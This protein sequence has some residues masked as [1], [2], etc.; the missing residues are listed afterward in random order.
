MVRNPNYHD[1]IVNDESLAL[2]ITQQEAL[3][4]ELLNKFA[5]NPTLLEGL[6]LAA[7][8]FRSPKI[9]IAL[10][11]Y[12]DRRERGKRIPFGKLCCISKQALLSKRGIKA[13]IG[14]TSI[15]A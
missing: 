6:D 14:T 3:H 5:D 13:S 15:E 9:K 4:A 1:L 7:N 10:S 2:K 11:L 12:L 8:L